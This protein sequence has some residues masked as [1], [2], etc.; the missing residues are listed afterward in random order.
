MANAPAT[1][2]MHSGHPLCSKYKC[3]AR[4]YLQTG[5]LYPLSNRGHQTANISLAGMIYTYPGA[6]VRVE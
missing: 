2:K 1:D 5:R 3:M 4:I 6:T